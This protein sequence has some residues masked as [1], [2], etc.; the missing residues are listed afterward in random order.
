MSDR[1]FKKIE[2]KVF[3]NWLYQFE[4]FDAWPKQEDRWSLL[5]K[6][7]KVKCLF[8]LE[9]EVTAVRLTAD[10]QKSFLTESSSHLNKHSK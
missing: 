9:A 7:L 3:F 8:F 5:I 6:S 1:Q 2:N 10:V 4:L